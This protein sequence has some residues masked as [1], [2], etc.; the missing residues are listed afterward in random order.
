MFGKKWEY[1][2]FAGFDHTGLEHHFELMAQNGWMIDRYGLV[3]SYKK[4][5]PADLHFS[6]GFYPEATFTDPED[7]QEMTFDDFCEA[8]GWKQAAANGPLKIFYTEEPDPIPLDTD[9]KVQIENVKQ[10]FGRDYIQYGLVF[11][12]GIAAVVIGLGSLL[13][14][15][16]KALSSAGGLLAVCFLVLVGVFYSGSVIVSYHLW[17]KKAE[18]NAE[19]E[20]LTPTKSYPWIRKLTILVIVAFLIAVCMQFN[21]FYMIVL[22]LFYIMVYSLGDAITNILRQKRVRRELNIVITYAV[23][24]VFVIAFFTGYFKFLEKRSSSS[25]I[26][27]TQDFYM[28]GFHW[29]FDERNALITLKDLGR[30]ESAYK[31]YYDQDGEG[32][33]LMGWYHAQVEMDLYSENPP[34]VVTDDMEDIPADQDYISYT[35]VKSRVDWL[36]RFAVEQLKKKSTADTEWTAVSDAEAKEMGADAVYVTET[37]NREAKGR[38]VYRYLFDLSDRAVCMDTTFELTAEQGNTISELMK[39]Q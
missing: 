30:E 38:K 37:E 35:A 2:F 18:K 15:S 9:P 20:M 33:V 3:I 31:I 21:N 25:E 28:G 22:L 16:I 39:A 26:I 10:S 19:N 36:D 1:N 6:V 8:A 29:D 14:D 5:E 32:S 24:I 17:M 4:A 7:E 23:L 13:Q 27:T 11:L 12:M 34:E